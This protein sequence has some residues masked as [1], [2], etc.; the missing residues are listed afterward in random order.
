MGGVAEETNHSTVPVSRTV[1][2]L[3]LEE[4]EFKV[5]TK[6]T[7][8]QYDEPMQFRSI[9]KLSN[10]RHSANQERTVALM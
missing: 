7:D 1:L 4:I 8:E 2:I 6:A 9:S 5:I 10:R 3:N